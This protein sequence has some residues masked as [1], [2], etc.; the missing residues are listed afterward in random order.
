MIQQIKDILTIIISTSSIIVSAYALYK[1]FNGPRAS[2]EKRV[3]DLEDQLKE[4]QEELSKDNEKLRLQEK[5]NSV[6]KAVM[7]SFVDFEI[8]YCLNT[9]YKDVKDLQKA[10]T[11][12]QDYLSGKKSY[13]ED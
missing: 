7:L 10:K 4:I 11:I 6:F 8:A 13:E 12:L 3:S 1:F 5:E 9:G 2:L